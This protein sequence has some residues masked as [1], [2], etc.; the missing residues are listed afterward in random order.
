MSRTSTPRAGQHAWFIR[1]VNSVE[2]WAPE[3]IRGDVEERTA[4]GWILR[5]G[6]ELR[7]LSE[8]EWSVYRP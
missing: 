8:N 2:G 7:E 3:T 5:V 4:T 6:T 1:Y